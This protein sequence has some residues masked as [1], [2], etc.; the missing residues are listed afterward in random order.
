MPDEPFPHLDEM[1]AIKQM[2]K[3]MNFDVLYLALWNIVKH[4]LRLGI[5]ALAIIQGYRYLMDGKTGFSL[6]S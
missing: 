1:N 2:G 4:P 3:K 6:V 5:G